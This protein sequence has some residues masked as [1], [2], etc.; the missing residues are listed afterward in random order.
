MSHVI[1]KNGNNYDVQSDLI[2]GVVNSNTFSQGVATATAT[3]SST[4]DDHTA[5]IATKVTKDNSG[6]IEST[7]KI[8]AD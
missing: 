5:A 8:S 1:V 3:L 2:S 6:N 7:V 4:V